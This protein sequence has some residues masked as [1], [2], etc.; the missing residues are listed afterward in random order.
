MPI[1]HVMPGLSWAPEIDRLK[2][3]PNAEVVTNYGHHVYY[4]CFNMRCKPL[5]SDV[6]RQAIAH[7]VDRD[8]IIEKVFQGTVLPLFSFLPPSSAF[9][10]DDVPVRL[11]DPIEAAKILDAAGYT[12]DAAAKIRKDPAT[13][14]QMQEL[15]LLAPMESPRILV[16]SVMS[17][18]RHI[19]LKN[20]QT[21][22]QLLVPIQTCVILFW[23]WMNWH[24]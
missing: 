17:M 15:R 3:D 5:D 4:L 10:K 2:A 14:K 20:C 6:L 23:G 1:S 11:F 16:T 13:G 22:L 9:Y 8:S 24:E 7:L 21:S 19:L 18:R 12:M